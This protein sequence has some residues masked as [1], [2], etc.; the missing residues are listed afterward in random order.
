MSE[1]EIERL[2]EGSTQL[3]LCN[4]NDGSGEKY[5]IMQFG[6][7]W[8]NNDPLFECSF[9]A[10]FRHGRWSCGTCEDLQKFGLN[11]EAACISWCHK[12]GFQPVSTVLRF[13][14]YCHCSTYRRNTTLDDCI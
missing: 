7:H 1:E 12:H 5:F 13:F 9:H 4:C 2:F 8:L 6:T 10:R 11:S 3:A 14:D